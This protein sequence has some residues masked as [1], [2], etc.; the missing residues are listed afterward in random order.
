M[1]CI[2]F[3]RRYVCSR[4]RANALTFARVTG[5]APYGYH[6]QPRPPARAARAGAGAVR[7]RSSARS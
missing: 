7:S 1:R 2:P 4:C 6:F 3:S 5:P